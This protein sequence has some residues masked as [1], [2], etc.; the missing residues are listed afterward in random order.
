MRAQSFTAESVKIKMKIISIVPLLLLFIS[1]CSQVNQTDNAAA[2]DTLSSYLQAFTDKN[3]ARLSS[4]VCSAWSSDSFLEYDS[5]Q[6]VKT[7][8]EGLSCKASAG[9]DGAV[10]V[11]CQGKI[12]A[13]YQ[14][15]AQEFNL[16]KRVYRLEK[17]GAD[18]VVCGYSERSPLDETC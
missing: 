15:E 6:G 8:L 1:G 16:C 14:N 18:W 11:S 12:L 17:I 4:L 2:L 3:E 7:Q 13:S 10:L 5:F 9:E